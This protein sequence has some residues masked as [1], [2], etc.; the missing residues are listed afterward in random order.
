MYIKQ[1]KECLKQNKRLINLNLAFQTFG[2]V[3]QKIND[4]YFVI[5]PSGI[6]LKKI[7]YSDFPTVSFESSNS[8]KNNL[9]PSVDTPTH[10]ILMKT[11][12]S[13]GGIA[14]CHSEYATSWAQSNKPIPILG[15]THADYWDGPVPITDNLKMNEIKSNYELNIGK[16]IIKKLKELKYHNKLLKNSSACPGMLV[17]GHGTFAWGGNALE[18]V[19]NARLI[20]Y[21]AKIAFNTI[22]I[23]NKIKINKFLFKKHYQRKND[24]DSYYGQKKEK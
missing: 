22:I 6:D 12:P 14:H 21:V 8:L 5:K 7:K 9:N 10:Q 17:R 16:S 13:I 24:K 3:S 2:N 15:T 23:N 4:K 11:Y 1:K 19:N 18:A 20:E